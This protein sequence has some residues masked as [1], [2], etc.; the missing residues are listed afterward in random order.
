MKS[1]R[2]KARSLPPSRPMSWYTPACLR[3]PFGS[4]KLLKMLMFRSRQSVMSLPLTRRWLLGSSRSP[5]RHCSAVLKRSTTSRYPSPGWVYPTRIIWQ[6]ASRWKSSINQRLKMWIGLCG[7]RGHISPRW[8]L[9]FIP[10]AVTLRERNPIRLHWQDLSMRS[11]NCRCW[12][13][14]TQMRSR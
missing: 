13:G 14:Q 4:V 3:F 9:C 2:F 12:C 5:T 1:V 11:A 6:W 7:C 10:I 8:H